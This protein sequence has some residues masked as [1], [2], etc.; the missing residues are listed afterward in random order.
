MVAARADTRAEPVRLGPRLCARRI[1]RRPRRT[2]PGGGDPP[3]PRDS[4][5]GAAFRLQPR[6][7]PES[8]PRGVLRVPALPAADGRVLALAAGRLALRL[9]DLHARPGHEPPEPLAR[10]PRPGDDPRLRP[11]HGQR[12][13]RVEARPPAGADAHPA[14]LSLGRGLRDVHDVRRGRAG[15][16]L[17][18]QPPMVAPAPAARA[19]PRDPG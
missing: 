7:A 1:R 10:L 15:P 12:A 5:R 3:R 6:D 4:D 8:R 2:R 16:W 13:R 17:R 9:L 11:R 18:A 19:G 14:V